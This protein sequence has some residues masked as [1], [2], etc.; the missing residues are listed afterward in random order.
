M[1][2]NTA[3]QNAGYPAWDGLAATPI[4]IRHHVHFSFTFHVTAA[5][6]AD[7]VFNV[8]SAPPSAG[9]PCVPGAFVPVPEVLTCVDGF[10]AVPGAQAS[11]TIPAGTPVGSVCVAALPC[12]PDAFVRLASGG[13]DVANVKV[14]AVLSGP[15]GPLP[16]TDRLTTGDLLSMTKQAEAPAQQEQPEQQPA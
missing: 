11:I 12:R 14:I 2:F 9:D 13:G 1:L 10:A 4:D 5:I 6:A 3:S 16:T 15:R 8:Q 7:A